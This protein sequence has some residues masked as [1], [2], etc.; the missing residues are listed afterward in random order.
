MTIDYLALLTNIYAI[1]TYTWGSGGLAFLYWQLGLASRVY[2]AQIVAYL[3]I[4]APILLF[5]GINYV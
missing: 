2:V 5:N 1:R 3:T 4:Y